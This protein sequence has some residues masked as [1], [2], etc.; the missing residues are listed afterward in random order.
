MSLDEGHVR[1]LQALRE[2]LNADELRPDDGRG[3]WE[4]MRVGIRQL[5]ASLAA[6]LMQA[7]AA[8]NLILFPYS[9]ETA[10]HASW[11]RSPPGIAAAS[12]RAEKRGHGGRGRKGLG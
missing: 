4:P 12:R 10:G 1:A 3:D 2:A 8:V 11:K 5:R 6:A 9:A 7:S